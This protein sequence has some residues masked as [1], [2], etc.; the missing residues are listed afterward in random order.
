MFE[1]QRVRADHESSILDFELANRSYFVASI[2]DRGDDYFR[3]FAQHHRDLLAAQDAGDILCYVLL[4]EDEA[5]VGRFNLYDIVD[6]TADVGYRVAQRVA[7]RGVATATLEN[8][9]RIANEEYGIVRLRAAT[10]RENVAS[11]Q[12]LRKAGFMATGPTEVAGGPG[13]SFELV[14]AGA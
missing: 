10:P 13:L 4:D 6:G 8:F 2:N 7:G 1:L 12:V 11:Q 9:C 5:V 3:D 14:F